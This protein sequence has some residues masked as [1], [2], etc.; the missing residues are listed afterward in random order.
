MGNGTK[1]RIKQRPGHSN[2]SITFYCVCKKV[3]LLPLYI[4]EESFIKLKD[5]IEKK[6]ELMERK[7]KIK[8]KWITEEEQFAEIL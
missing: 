6:K 8:S 7:G 5:A 2:S 4:E 1:F 3:P